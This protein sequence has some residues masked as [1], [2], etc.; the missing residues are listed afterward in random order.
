V[1]RKAAEH[2]VSEEVLEAGESSHT[3]HDH[4]GVEPSE[5]ALGAHLVSDHA[6]DIPEGLSGGTLRGVHDRFH[7]EAHA[8]E[9]EA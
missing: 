3:D 6:A 1:D 2:E 5:D 8:T 4:D 9:D 7:G